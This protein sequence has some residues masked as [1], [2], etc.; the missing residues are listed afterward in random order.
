MTVSARDINFTYLGS[1]HPTLDVSQLEFRGG[2]VSAL[3]G[4]NGSGKS[5][6]LLVLCAAIPHVVRGSFNGI[7][8]LDGEVLTLERAQKAIRVVPQASAEMVLGFTP[9]DE[10]R[11]FACGAELR[12]VAADLVAALPPDKRV[13]RLSSGERHRLGI[14][15][16]LCSSARAVLFDEPYDFLDRDA[17]RLAATGFEITARDGRIVIVADRSGRPDVPDAARTYYLDRGRLTAPHVIDSPCFK[18]ILPALGAI[19][20][21]V[22]Q[23]THQFERDGLMVLRN[24]SFEAREGEILGIQGANGAG[25][26]TLLLILAGLL[27]SRRSGIWMG[28]EPKPVT[29]STRRARAKFC[30]A[31]ADAQLF[32]ASGAAELHFGV[33]LL[34]KPSAEIL[35]RLEQVTGMLPFD[36]S[37]DP[38]TYSQGQRKLLAIA[39]MFII[40]TDLWLLDEP[41]ASLDSE[42]QQKLVA[43]IEQFARRGGTVIIASHDDR[44]LEAVTH[45]RLLLKNGEV[46]DT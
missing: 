16:A 10:L 41:T 43:L 11:E 25:K 42:G 3:L 46:H 24:V 33:S 30:V 9:A 38:F 40:A 44:F 45:R 1:A 34:R 35:M 26:T 8:E 18:I 20:I 4:G 36:L 31:D 7:V 15:S 17:R 6:V 29:L 2:E 23:L 19:A 27:G 5:T 28:R 37:A 14:A 22:S 39:C 13:D 12:E 21:R 32:C